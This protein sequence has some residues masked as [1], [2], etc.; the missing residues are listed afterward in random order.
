MCGSKFKDF[1]DNVLDES[2]NI[3]PPED[4]YEGIKLFFYLTELI[5]DLDQ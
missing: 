3:S 4:V 1:A 5:D 2:H